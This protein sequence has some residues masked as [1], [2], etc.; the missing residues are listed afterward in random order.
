MPKKKYT[1]EEREELLAKFF[2]HKTVGKTK[3]IESKLVWAYMYLIKAVAGKYARGDKIS[4]YDDFIQLGSI[5]L[6]KAL[7]NYRIDSEAAFETYAVH[8][9]TGEIRHYIRDNI[10]MIKIP[11]AYFAIL[12]KI[13]IIY[14]EFVREHDREPTF[15][16]VLALLNDTPEISK[17]KI[18]PEELKQ[19]YDV[20]FVDSLNMRISNDNDDAES[21]ELIDM[22]SEEGYKSFQLSLDDKI[23]LKEALVTL[24]K[25]FPTFASIIK[26]SFYYDLTQA[27]IAKKM[28]ISQMEVSRS[29]K[30]GLAELWKIMNKKVI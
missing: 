26:F 25:T 21:A 9:I 23:A 20:Y 1:K 8:C 28:G 18:E 24:D 2:S 15:D 11:P 27:E 13:N 29:L 17:L 4:Y 7:A 19:L 3:D 5:G 10:S 30:K 14:L 6:I 16:D 22:I 12:N